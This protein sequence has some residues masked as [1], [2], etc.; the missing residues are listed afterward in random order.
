MSWVQKQM[1]LKARARGFHLIT[2][3]VVESLPEIAN[4]RVGLLQVFIRHTSASLT[5][6]ENADSDVPRDLESS[7]NTLAPEDFPYVH[8]IEGPDDMPAHVKASLMGSSVSIPIADGRLL[9]GAWQ[10][11]YLC[12][13]RNRASGRAPY[14]RHVY[15]RPLT[16]PRASSADA[17]T[18][19]KLA[20]MPDMSDAQ[21]VDA[22]DP[23]QRASPAFAG[24]FTSGR[25][26]G[27][28][29]RSGAYFL[30]PRT[31]LTVLDTRSMH[32]LRVVGLRGDFSFDAISPR[33]AWIYLIHYV[34][35]NDP[36]RYEVRALDARTGRLADDPVVDPHERGEA[37]RGSPV[38]RT[39]SADGRWAYTLYDG[40]G[41]TPFVHALDTRGR[42]A[43]CI[44][45]D[46]LPANGDLSNTRLKQV[47]GTLSVVR[48]GA[49]VANVDLASFRVSE[50]RVASP[51]GDGGFPFVP[52]TGAAALALLLGAALA[53]A[54][55]RGRQ[56][57]VPSA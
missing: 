23:L 24:R 54:V 25:A 41:K 6:N 55:R 37:M 16:R 34:S 15:R 10:G 48:G 13:H 49:P 27:S 44:D 14:L 20:F 12:E 45:L 5:I 19:V 28:S 33:G 4:V 46:M 9:L 36:T 7:L 47:R 52:V 43:R 39:T 29:K 22:P 53:F 26:T 21:P 8:T 56:V 51:G 31:A 50:P 32:P 40:G 17:R 2:S 38:T 18:L 1:T 35:P 11:V 57:S 3:E 42:T 30:F